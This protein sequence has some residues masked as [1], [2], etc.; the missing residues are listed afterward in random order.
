MQKVALLFILISSVAFAQQEQVYETEDY[1]VTGTKTESLSRDAAIRTEVVGK[2]T[3]RESGASNL[4]DVLKKGL[5]PNVW[6]ETSC[7][8]CNFASVRMQGLEGDYSMILIDGQ[9]T[10]SALASIYGLSQIQADTIEKIEVVK[11]SGSALYGS[12][13]IGGVINII[14]R[15]P[16]KGESSASVSQNIGQHSTFDTAVSTSIRHE[17]FAIVLGAQRYETDYADETGPFGVPDQYT[18]RV[19]RNNQSMNFKG[20]YYAKDDD[21]RFTLFGRH[22]NEFRRGGYL[23]LREIDIDGDGT[24]DTELPAIDN[25]MDEDS[26]HITTNRSEFGFGYKEKFED[27][28]VV[29]FMLTG[30]R[31]D[32]NATNGARPF[33][34]FEKMHLADLVVNK[35]VGEMNLVT[36]GLSWREEKLEETINYEVQGIREAEV[37]GVYIQDEIFISEDIELITGIRYDKTKSTLMDDSAFSPRFGL[38]YDLTSNMVFRL[39][40]GGGFRVPYLFAEDLHLCSSAPTVVTADDIEPEKSWSSSASLSWYADKFSMDATLFRTDISDKIALGFVDHPDYDAIYDNTGDA[41]IQGAEFNSRLQLTEMVSFTVAGALNDATYESPVGLDFPD[42]ENV[43]RVPENTLSIG[44]E[45]RDETQGFR[46]AV[47]GRRTGSMYIEKELVQ[48]IGGQEPGYYVDHT[49]SY[50][51]VNASI[52][53]QFFEGH[54]AIYANIENLTDEKQEVNYNAEYENT[55]AYIYAPLTGRYTMVGARL[56]F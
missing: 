48:A 38:K 56:K 32:R 33:V 34:S 17:N 11:G 42:T 27:G 2:N 30:S 36:T 25:P 10:F 19:E 49:K 51:T 43:M 28:S 22:L 24:P 18:D 55:A 20:H 31:H 13:A 35:P 1:V 41:I 16:A 45:F 6:V 4:F 39:N 23:G 21:R 15:E 14:T 47:D 8:N 3:I 5:V 40:S 37:A 9:P 50:W 46:V 44:T 26:E 52:E 7:T 53:K 54:L 29:N 12:A